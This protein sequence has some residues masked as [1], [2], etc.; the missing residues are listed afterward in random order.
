LK[1]GVE[2]W[3]EVRVR[4]LG[5][6]MGR[7]GVLMGRTN[8]FFSREM[9]LFFRPRTTFFRTRNQH[10][11]FRTQATFFR[12]ISSVL[13]SSRVHTP[14][15]TCRSRLDPLPNPQPH[16]KWL[17]FA[18]R[19]GGGLGMCLPKQQQFSE[20]EVITTIFRAI[21]KKFRSHNNNFQS[22]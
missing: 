4:G 2:G 22:H 1:R 11:F 15:P 5:G 17:F 7:D 3:R 21:N 16:P 20:L 10:F 19:P 14:P 9:A 8:H 13:A 6:G 18:R 12:T